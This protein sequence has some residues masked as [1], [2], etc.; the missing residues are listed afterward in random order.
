MTAGVHPHAAAGVAPGWLAQLR[1]LLGEEGVVA[2]GECGL[3]YHYD[4]APRADQLRV[5][6]A[7]IALAAEC[8]RPLVVH[9]REAESDLIPLM[10]E[11]GQGGV[12]GVLHAFSGE[13]GLLES[14]LDA[15]WNVSFTGMVT[16]RNFQGIEG[17]RRVPEGRYMLETDGPYL[18]P[19]PHRGGRNEPA[20]L[21]YIRDR[22]A[23]LRGEAPEVVERASTRAA[24][25][26]FGLP[27]CLLDT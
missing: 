10:K 7:Q 6:R 19:V 9:C 2:V 4:F 25:A 17:V 14:A 16:F 11:A 13:L 26:F 21:P 12:R 27:H 1:A 15:G 5:F 22:V 23:E 20:L 3:D 8:G 24:I 18:A